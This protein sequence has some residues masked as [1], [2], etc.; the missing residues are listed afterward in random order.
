MSD[1]RLTFSEPLRLVHHHPGQLRLRARA[2]I[3]APADHPAVQAVLKTAAATSG[4]VG[5]SHSGKTGSIVL[6]YQPGRWDVD[7]LLARVAAAAGFA[8]VSS[9]KTDRVHREEVVS[10][11]L[12]TVKGM[13][14]IAHEACG[15]RADL[16]ELIPGALAV[17]SLL[18]FLRN[19]DGT[20]L[21]RWDNALWW[22]Q[23]LFADW[24]RQEIGRKQGAGSS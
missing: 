23:S 16:R 20:R 8:G 12:D 11:L 22:C 4:F 9:D 2:L 10:I 7:A 21:P 18:S 6:R 14:E 3:G 13:N 19:A 17:V 15:G 1:P 24:H 5:W